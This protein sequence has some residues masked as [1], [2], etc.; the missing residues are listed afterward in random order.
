MVLRVLMKMKARGDED[1]SHRAPAPGVEEAVPR[2]EAPG[3]GRRRRQPLGAEAP[4]PFFF[5]TDGG[6]VDGF[7]PL[8]VC[9]Q[10]GGIS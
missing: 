9:C 4:C 5:L 1:G 10:R 2:R 7:L 6:D 3:G 8:L